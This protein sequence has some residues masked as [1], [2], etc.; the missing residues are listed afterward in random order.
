MRSGGASPSGSIV[1]V[2]LGGLYYRYG[3]WRKVQLMPAVGSPANGCATGD[4]C[5]VRLSRTPYGFSSSP[6][7]PRCARIA[8]LTVF[9]SRH[10]IVIGPTPPGTGVIAP[11][12]ASAPA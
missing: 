2:V 10:A 1:G 8:A 4:R 9:S 5:R 12:R 7:A 3:G 6:A 11:A